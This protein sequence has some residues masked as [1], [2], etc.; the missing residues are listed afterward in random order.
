LSYI[1]KEFDVFIMT[2]GTQI[3]AEKICEFIRKKFE[4][5]FKKYPNNKAFTKEWLV[6]RERLEVN[7]K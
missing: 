4:R 3:Y 2:Y 7:S 5:V 6:A 1:L